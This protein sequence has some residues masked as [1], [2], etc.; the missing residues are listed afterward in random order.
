MIKSRWT[1]HVARR[2]E[3]YTKGFGGKQERGRSLGKPRHD[4]KMN[5]REKG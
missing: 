1:G 3:D 2:A 4:I 5:L